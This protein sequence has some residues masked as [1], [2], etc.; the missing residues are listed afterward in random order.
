MAEYDGSI[1]INTKIETKEASAQLMTLENRIVK[2]ADKISSLRSKMDALKD[3]KIPTEEYKSIQS[4]ISKAEK[5]LEKL[6]E[7]QAQMQ[8]DGKASGSAWDTL[9]Q[10]IQASKDYI[11]QAKEEMQAL[12]DSGKAFTLGSDSAEYS[13]LSQQLQYAENDMSVLAQRHDELTAKQENV[14]SGFAKIGGAAKKA[15][16]VAKNAIS[17]AISATKKVSSGIKDIATRFLHI[18]KNAKSASTGVNSLGIGFKNLLKYGFGIRSLYVLVNKFRTAVKEGFANL[19][20]FSAPVNESISSIMSALTQLKNSLATA[21]APILTAVAPALTKLINLTSKAATAVGMLTAALTGKKTFTKAKAVQQD[22]AESLKSTASNAKKAEKALKGYLSPL[23]EIN[24]INKEDDSSDALGDTQDAGG[25]KPEDM[26]EEV[27]IPDKF[28]DIAKW[29]KDMW[30]KADFTELGRFLGEKLKNALDGIDWEP[31]KETAAKIGKS[32]ATL[33]NGFV[34]VPGLAY[35]IGRTIGEAINTGIIGINAFLDNTHWDSVGKFIGEGLNGIVNTID[36]KAIGHMFAAKWN[37]IFE[38]IGNFARTFNWKKFGKSITDSI[39]TFIKDFDWAGN[40]T[41]LSDFVKGFL[42]AI[43]T[44]FEETDWQALGDGIAD[45]FGSIDWTGIVERLAEGIG[46][47]LGGFSA[48]IGGLIGDAVKAAKEYFQDEIEEVGGNI[49]LGILKGIGDAIIGI[50]E[51]IYQHVF[52]PIYDGFCK[53]FGI[54]SPSKVMAELGVYIIQGLLN[55]IKSLVG[56]VKQVWNSMKEVAASVWNG[57]KDK[58]SGIWDSINQKASTTWDGIKQKISEKWESIKTDT[59]AK[60]ES[61]NGSLSATWDGIKSKA[62]TTWDSMSSSTRSKMDGIKSAMS[63]FSA[64]A[65][66]IWRNAWNGMNNT[67]NSVLNSMKSAVSSV[68]SW[69][70]S[71]ISSIKSS[72]SSV[73]SSASSFSK[74]S[75]SSSKARIASYDTYSM[76]YLSESDIPAYATGQVIPTSMK[77]HLAVLGDNSRETEVVSPLSTIEKAVENVLAR[78]GAQTII[79]KQYLDGKQVAESVVKEGKIQQM[80]TGNNMFALGTT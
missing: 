49:V 46:A 58:L 35:S 50:G 30:D 24:K 39:N 69:I 25:L 33:I 59:S 4:D 47:A 63:G 42:D 9:Q 19:A 72:I 8:N 44:F 79:I 3:T 65:Q 18:G 10:K 68:F 75:G 56:S 70:S 80:A 7:K 54:A 40:G 13:K 41:N 62:S 38:T 76:P 22:Y 51:W 31:I 12:I 77:K 29:L 2:T 64:S 73:S 20:Q 55:G 6:L 23:D 5:E 60:W 26:F 27:S 78:T 21:F 67:I 16:S 57:V 43:I 66:S 61:I 32:I 28:K 48:L 74:S 15:F 1:R 14:S 52:K 17:G 45:F 34:E 11:A 37:A 36:W 71:K 53:A